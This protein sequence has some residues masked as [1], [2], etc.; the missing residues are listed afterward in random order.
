MPRRVRPTSCVACAPFEVWNRFVSVFRR[1]RRAR[2]CAA[3]ELPTSCGKVL[4]PRATLG[5]VETW[6]FRTAE[7]THGFPGEIERF[8]VRLEKNFETSG[9][10][11]RRS[12]F[13][14]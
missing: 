6:M 13:S 4:P 8:R 10:K 3:L 1:R 9:K 7:T 12:P 2:A 11:F 14:K 5:G